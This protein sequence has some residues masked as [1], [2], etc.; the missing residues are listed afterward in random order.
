MALAGD[1]GWE[2]VNLAVENLKES[3]Y[4]FTSL[5]YEESGEEAEL[6]EEEEME[7]YDEDAE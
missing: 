7:E 1:G 6:D 5:I 3:S 4:R 2:E